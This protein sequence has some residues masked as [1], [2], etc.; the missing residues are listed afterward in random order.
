MGRRRGHDHLWFKERV[1]EARDAATHDP[2]SAIDLL[3][4]LVDHCREAATHGLSDWHEIQALWLLG[5]EFERVG[6]YAD[7]A[8]AYGRII[9]SRRLALREASAGLWSAL[10][11][12][13]ACEFRAG[14]R[15]TGKQLATEVLRDGATHVTATDLRLLKAEMQA[16]GSRK[17][18]RRPRRS[19]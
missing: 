9:S 10:A 6:R 2:Q 14:H 3:E 16:H 19:R 18:T 4:D 17:T 13:A 15:R 11:A 8:A 7:A 1:Q 5:T 12:A